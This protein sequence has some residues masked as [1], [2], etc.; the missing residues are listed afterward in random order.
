MVLTHIIPPVPNALVK[1]MFLTGVKEHF[2][3]PVVVAED[4]MRFYLEPKSD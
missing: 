3:G 1:R 2:S 4:R